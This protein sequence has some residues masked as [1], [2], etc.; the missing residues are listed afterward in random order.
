[1]YVPAHFKPTDD[2]VREL[3]RHHGAADLITAT[4][5]GLLATMLPL[6]WAESGA[7]ADRPWGALH[8]HVAR[9][10]QQW[11]VATTSEAL[12]IVRGPDAYISP[13]GYATKREHGRVVPTWNYVTAHVY[14]ELIVH[15]DPAWVE[16]NVRA[17]TA[18]HEAIRTEPWSVDDAPEP[19]I[20][21]QLK[22]IVGV[23]IR[24]ERVEGKVKL[25]QN[26]SDADIAGTIEGL[27]ARG[28]RDVAAAMRGLGRGGG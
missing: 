12:V 2:E 25:S 14:G 11:R 7:G 22:A 4:D 24:I 3:L 5:E 16:A 8:G 15:D 19:Y 6:I 23:E 10:N 28:E 20:D 9:N 18:K 17:L 21:G 1:V 26:R 13:S 27:E